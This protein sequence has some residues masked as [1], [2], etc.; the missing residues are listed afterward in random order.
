MSGTSPGREVVADYGRAALQNA[1]DLIA[2][3]RLLFNHQRWP[4]A[5]SLA[6]LATEEVAKAFVCC[7]LP[8]LPDEAAPHFGWPLDQVSRTHGLKLEMAGMLTHVLDFYMGGPNAPTRYP[9]DLDELAAGRKEDNEHKKRGLYV[10]LNDAQIMLPS[11]ISEQHATDA[12]ER[13]ARLAAVATQIV[14]FTA[15]LP[16]EVLAARGDIWNAMTGAYEQGGLD[17]MAELSQSTFGDLSEEAMAQ[18][19]ETLQ[20]MTSPANDATADG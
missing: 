2:D 15:N 16:G 1:H 11:E 5:C 9:S 19:R 20:Q 18:M 6:I 10:G 3:A 17:G 7:I 8:M 12:L 4:R 13:A 14:N